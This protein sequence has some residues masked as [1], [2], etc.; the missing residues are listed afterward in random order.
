MDESTENKGVTLALLE[1]FQTQRLPRAL[2]LKERIDQGGLLNDFDITFLETI[3]RESA[4]IRTR[5]DKHPE[6][7]PLAAQ[8]IHLYHEITTKALENEKAQGN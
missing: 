8:I 1:R 6:Y 4:S 3:F 5:L 2:A 7:Q